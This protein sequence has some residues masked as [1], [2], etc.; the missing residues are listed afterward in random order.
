MNLFLCVSIFTATF[1]LRFMS[2]GFCFSWRFW[3]L[4]ICNLS[5][6]IWVWNGTFRFI[7]YFCL[8]DFMVPGTL[9]N[10]LIQAASTAW[11][12][13]Y[14]SLLCCHYFCKM[15]SPSEQHWHRYDF[16][17]MNTIFFLLLIKIYLLFIVHNYKK[18]C[19][20]SFIFFIV[21]GFVLL[22]ITF[23]INN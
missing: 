6:R 8:A 5:R 4:H 23:S 22:V 14:V 16:S 11:W 9:S 18:I 3:D 7:Q 2:N 17:Y 12:L 19:H 1:V 15:D 21:R 13:L 20:F 10:H